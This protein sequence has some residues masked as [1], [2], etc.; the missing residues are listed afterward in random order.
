MCQPWKKRYPVRGWL[1]QCR[2]RDAR[3]ITPG[4]PPPV[5]L[6]RRRSPLRRGRLR[7]S[8]RGAAGGTG[9]CRGWVAVAAYRCLPQPLRPRGEPLGGPDV[10]EQLHGREGVN[11]RLGKPAR[12]FG[13]LRLSVEADTLL[14]PLDILRRT[15]SDQLAEKVVNDTWAHG[16]QES[17][18]ARLGSRNSWR[19]IVHAAIVFEHIFEDKEDFLT[20]RAQAGVRRSGH[21]VP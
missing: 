21:D 5:A 9:R 20:T 14:F 18:T 15:A 16:L 7:Q 12:K 3:Q 19:W 4:R 8:G 11:V 2:G 1:G 6:P 10:V 13:T 17:A